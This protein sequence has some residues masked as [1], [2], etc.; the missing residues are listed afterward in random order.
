LVLSTLTMTA[1]TTL[2]Q[3]DGAQRFEEDLLNAS[4]S[5]QDLSVLVF[6]NR[7]Q[8]PSG[9][10]GFAVI[11]FFNLSTNEFKQCVNANFDLRIIS[12]GRAT[13]S[14]VT[15]GGFNCP[16]GEEIVVSCEST[17]DSA[18]LYNVAN[19]TATLGSLDQQF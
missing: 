18:L 4:A 11:N 8:N 19:G 7:S 17:A 5:T 6:A 10:F 3:S 14:F 12:G 2:A 16:I 15:E 9:T 13:L 1:A